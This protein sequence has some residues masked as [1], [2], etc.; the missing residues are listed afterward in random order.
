MACGKSTIGAKL[1]E[2]LGFPFIDTDQQIERNEGISIS[3][4]FAEQGEGHFRK[5]EKEVIASIIQ[6]YENVVVSTG[7]GL[8]CSDESIAALLNDGTVI[9][10]ECDTRTLFKRI[11][12]QSAERPLAPSSEQEL[13]LHLSPRL[14]YYARAHHIIDGSKDVENIVRQITDVL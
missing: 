5:R 8:P 7:G 6:Q 3:H 10:L 14:K 4:I 9:Y 13:S 12:I 11:A 1:A 2:S